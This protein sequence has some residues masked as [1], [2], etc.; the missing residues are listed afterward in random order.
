MKI[1]AI[2]SDVEDKLGKASVFTTVEVT[3]IPPGVVRQSMVHSEYQR[4]EGRWLC[5]R[6]VGVRGVPHLSD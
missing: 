1:T 4:L 6:S 3:G 2:S 5:V